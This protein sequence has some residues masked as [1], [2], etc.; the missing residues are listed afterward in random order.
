MIKSIWFNIKDFEYYFIKINNMNFNGYFFSG[1]L[2]FALIII[3]IICISCLIIF[4][5]KVIR[6]KIN[7]FSFYANIII[8]CIFLIILINISNVTYTSTIKYKD[9]L[10]Y[11]ECG[12]RMGQINYCASIYEMD[13]TS[14][15]NIDQNILIKYG[16][17]TSPLT[18]PSG[19]TYEII[20]VHKS[21]NGD[22][23]CSK[24]NEYSLFEVLHEPCV[25]QGSIVLTNR[26]YIK[27]EN[28]NVGDTVIGYDFI[29]ETTKEAAILKTCKK[30]NNNF[31]I[32]NKHLYI[33][34][35]HRVWTKYGWK[36]SVT[37]NNND[38]LLFDNLNFGGVNLSF[39]KTRMLVYEIE[40]D[41]IHNYF[42][43]GILIHNSCL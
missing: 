31:I 16:Y 20:S 39:S 2:F 43:N 28:L 9:E 40:V 21:Q 8:I 5:H 41:G 35:M 33:T 10:L 18:C 15:V 42:C 29:N 27:V 37:I 34:I 13:N 7:K 3:Y 22:V 4:A 19:G 11:R 17:F 38:L 25:A 12:S 1:S 36:K 30:Y 14:N 26:G 6:I 23:I 32:I 24:H